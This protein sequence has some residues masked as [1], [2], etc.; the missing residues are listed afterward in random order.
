MAFPKKFA[1]FTDREGRAAFI[2]ETF[3]QELGDAQR[4]LDV[5]CDYN[6]LKKLV[7]DKV[8]GVDLYGEPDIRIDFEREHLKQFRAKHFDMVVCTEVLE[9]L[10]QLHAMTD[11][12][13][14][15]SRRYVLVSLPNCLNVFTK[16]NILFHNRVSKYYGLPLDPPEDRHR[17]FFS[18]QD[19]DRYFAHI[20]KQSQ[21]K[22]KTKFLVMNFSP[23]WKGKLLKHFVQL[24]GYDNA[25][26]SYWILLERTIA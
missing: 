13:L 20:A 23:S 21:F 18:Y 8:L 22:V 4:V 14:R 16:F 19:I 1:H 17:W 26:M 10:E 9:H 11:E 6:T 5:G 25:S 24:T 7:G 15:V 3:A 12:L 2:A